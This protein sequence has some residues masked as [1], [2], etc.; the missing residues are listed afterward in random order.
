MPCVRCVST[1]SLGYY[2][3]AP[4]NLCSPCNSACAS[5]TGPANTINTECISC[6]VGY[7]RSNPI[8]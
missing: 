2:F 1:C 3:N 8:T 6:A 4:A 5:C 7:F